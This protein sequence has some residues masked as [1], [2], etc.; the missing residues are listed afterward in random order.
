MLGSQVIVVP[1]TTSKI[2]KRDKPRNVII[3][4]SPY[5]LWHMLCYFKF[6]VRLIIDK[7]MN[8]RIKEN[9]DLEILLNDKKVLEIGCGIGTDSINFARAGARLTVV[10][11]SPKSLEICKKR[12]EV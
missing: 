5:Q 9:E 8:K 2:L 7:I 3:C 1:K 4:K 10:E 11:L 12:F 6:Y